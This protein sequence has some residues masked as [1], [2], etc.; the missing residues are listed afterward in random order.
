MAYVIGLLVTLGF[1][2][3]SSAQV[4]TAKYRRLVNDLF[5]RSRT[6][7]PSTV[8][9]V[10]LKV[11]DHNPSERAGLRVSLPARRQYTVSVEAKLKVGA[12]RDQP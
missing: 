2:S 7:P 1:A 11:S 12:C 6:R 9:N 10:A 3:A 5:R 8:T 4:D